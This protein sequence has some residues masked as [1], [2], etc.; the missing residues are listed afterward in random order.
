[1]VKL[2][3]TGTEATMYAI[4]FARAFTGRDKL[5]KFE[6]CFHGGHDAVLVNVKPARAKSGDPKRPNQVP[7]SLGIPRSVVQNTVVAPFNDIEA[8]DCIMRKHGDEVG[9]IIL[10]PIPMNMG[11][12]QPTPGF[13]EA[14]RRTADNYSSVLI[15]DEIKTCGKFYG[16]AQDH[17]K[18]KADL[19]TMG[20]AI[21]GG[22]PISAIG[23]RKQIM[24]TVVPGLVSHAGTFNSNPL[25]V[26]A[27]IVTLT[28]ILTKNRM[29]EITACSEKLAKAYNEIIEDVNLIAKVTWGGT[30]GAVAF[31]GHDVV[32]W[33]TFQDCDIGKWYAYCFA[34]MNRGVIPA[35]PSPDEQWTVSAQHEPE[36]IDAHVEAFKEV[37]PY[38]RKCENKAPIVEAI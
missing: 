32:N 13:I 16:G 4:R 2:S 37:A 8:L 28:E 36:D 24:E 33:R 15:F 6:G 3:T 9:A 23:G 34:M 29:Y 22:L 11:Y 10:E 35:G 38:V 19:I 27:G 17:F 20:K 12:V 30:S 1:M 31:T 21:G 18:I 7:A 14:V 25:S 5:L 26:T